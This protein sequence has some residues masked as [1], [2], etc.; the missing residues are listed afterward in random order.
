MRISVL[1][2]RIQMYS[3]KFI[4]MYWVVIRIRY[5][6]ESWSDLHRTHMPQEE[7]SE[8]DCRLSGSEAL[9]LSKLSGSRSPAT[10]S[11]KIV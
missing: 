5:F 6:L 1:L 9:E 2:I 4:F 8:G 3:N 11:H 7:T 10:P